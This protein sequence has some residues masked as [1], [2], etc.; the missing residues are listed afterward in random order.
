MSD[1]LP[2]GIARELAERISMEVSGAAFQIQNSARICIDDINIQYTRPCVV[3]KPRLSRDGD[4]WCMLFGEDL[5]S[6]V[7]GFGN[8]PEA[9]CDAFDQA[10]RSET[11]RP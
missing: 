2:P 9:A 10:W 4:Q 11:I 5:Q 7:A 1:I 8:T 6:G 3:F